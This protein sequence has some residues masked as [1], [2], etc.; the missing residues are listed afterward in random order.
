[1]LIFSPDDSRIG[2]LGPVTGIIGII[3]LGR[4]HTEINS[5]ICLIGYRDLQLSGIILVSCFGAAY[6]F[7]VF[8]SHLD[9]VGNK[10]NI[11]RKSVCDGNRIPAVQSKLIR[12]NNYMIVDNIFGKI[13]RRVVKF[14]YKLVGVCRRLLSSALCSV[15][16]ILDK[17][18]IRILFCLFRALNTD[19]FLSCEFR[20]VC[21]DITHPIDT[22]RIINPCTECINQRHRLNGS[23]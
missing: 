5:R 7:S 9:A 16:S 10:L 3:Q 20:L 2:I 8:I 6:Y 11:R 23:V 22:A 15:A 18:Y 1:M 12:I 13:R 21:Y 19:G 14:F 4:C 17:S